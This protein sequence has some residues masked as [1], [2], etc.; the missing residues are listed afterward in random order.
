MYIQNK[1]KENQTEDDDEYDNNDNDAVV[2]D[3]LNTEKSK[4][5]VTTVPSLRLD[6]VAKAGFGMSRAYVKLLFINSDFYK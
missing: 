2:D 3:Y 1:Y 5:I 6:A 4:I